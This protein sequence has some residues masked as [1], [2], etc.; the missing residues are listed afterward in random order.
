MSKLNIFGA[1]SY[2][3]NILSLGFEKQKK[4]CYTTDHEFQVH[5]FR[6]KLVIINN[7]ILVEVKRTILSI[8]HYIET[9]I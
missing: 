8:Y 6:T 7:I 1:V 5:N 9:L 3:T 4:I 2:F